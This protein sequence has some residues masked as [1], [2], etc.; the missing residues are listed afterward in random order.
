MAAFVAEALGDGEQVDGIVMLAGALSPDYPL[1]K[2]L[3]H[4][5]RGIVNYYSRFDWWFLAVGT[6][7]FGTSDGSHSQAAGRVG[8]AAPVGPD[9]LYQVAWHGRMLW[10]GNLGGHLTSSAAPYV[11]AYVAPVVKRN[12]WDAAFIGD[13]TGPKGQ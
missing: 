1:D 7:V 10:K 5:R 9:R 2:A 11:A 8:F 13:L 4:S 3:A 12:T 6:F